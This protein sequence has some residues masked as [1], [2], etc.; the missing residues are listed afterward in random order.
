MSSYK[1]T[2]SIITPVLNN[3]DSLIKT[4]NS[5]KKQKFKD[6]EF[7]V[8]D[9][10]SNDGSIEILNNEKIIDKWVSEKDNGIY[11]AI[12]K[13]IKIS[14][15]KY[16][17]TINSGDEYY[18]AE[19]LDIINKYFNENS[20]ISFVFGAVKKNK[21]YHKYEPKKMNWSF[22]LYPAHSGGFL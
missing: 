17:N 6:F 10:G 13:G 22:N 12:N 5:I 15:G 16:I 7:I 14:E 11:D 9:G 8:I 3:K 4:I 19:S 2:F 1:K 18:S 20:E 21:I